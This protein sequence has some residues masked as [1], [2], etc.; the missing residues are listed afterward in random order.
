MARKVIWAQAA[1]DD[2]ESIAEYIHR[3]SPAYTSSFVN[4]VMK[5]AR[6]LNNLSER[7]RMVPELNNKKIREIFIQSYRMIYHIED[8]RVYVVALIHGH[9]DFF[10]AWNENNYEV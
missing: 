2:L 3:D 1:L 10:T 9:R 5:R 6:T 4:L 7:G 8:D